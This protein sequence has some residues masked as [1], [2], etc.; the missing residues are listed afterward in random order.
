MSGEATVTPG[1]QLTAGQRWTRSLLNLLGIPVVRVNENSIGARE[2]IASEVRTLVP[3]VNRNILIN[4]DFAIFQR[5]GYFGANLVGLP[6][7]L[8]AEAGQAMGADRWYLGEASG[9]GKRTVTSGIVLVGGTGPNHYLHWEQVVAETGDY[10]PILSQLV[11]DATYL[12]GRDL[13]VTWRMKGDWTGDIT[14]QL[15]RFSGGSPGATTVIEATS[16]G[17][18]AV[19]TGQDWT[20]Y[21][22]KFTIPTMIGEDLEAGAYLALQFLLPDNDTFR[23]DFAE[24]QMEE[25][26][27][28]TAFETVPMLDQLRRCERYFEYHGG[29]AA[30]DLTHFQPCFYFATRKYRAPTLTLIAGYD[31]DMTEANFDTILDTGYKQSTANSQVS[32]FFMACEAEINMP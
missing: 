28:A 31:G 12:A 29:T 4:G 2:L 8:G 27:E 18:A 14:C 21:T 25:G 23:L 5:G 1:A 26:L 19:V 30:D 3:N 7:T 10:R 20:T 22:A 24:A 6:T 13:V 9:A 15:S 11:E 16:G 17:T 32:D